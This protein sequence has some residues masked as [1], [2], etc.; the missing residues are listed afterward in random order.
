MNTIITLEDKG[1]DAL[2]F[3]IENNIVSK[4]LPFQTEIWKDAYV[5][6]EDCEIGKEM[7]IHKPPHL[8]F[9]YLKY[10]IINIQ[11]VD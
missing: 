8:N 10:K 5:P 1:Q 6:I 7:P 11:T 3:I 2:Q 4:T 9:T